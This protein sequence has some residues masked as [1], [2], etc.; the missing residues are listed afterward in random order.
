MPLGHLGHQ[1]DGP[2]IGRYR[3]FGQPLTVECHRQTIMGDRDTFFEGDRQLQ[4]G[5][6]LGEAAAAQQCQAE[7][8]VR[9]RVRRVEP[10]RLA[11]RGDRGRQFPRPKQTDPLPAKALRRRDLPPHRRRMPGIGGVSRVRTSRPD[12][13][14]RVAECFR[15]LAQFP[16]FAQWPKVQPSGPGAPRQADGCRRGVHHAAALLEVTPA[17][18]RAGITAARTGHADHASSDAVVKLTIRWSGAERPSRQRVARNSAA[19]S[20]SHF[21]RWVPLAVTA[22]RR[23]LAARSCRQS[24]Q[25]D[26]ARG[27]CT[28]ETKNMANPPGVRRGHALPG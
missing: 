17:A 19:P 7:R 22:A 8:A 14:H 21:R 1:L 27:P 16:R 2:A 4:D 11:Q 13:V 25:W 18:A 12:P 3:L 26:R 20:A 28:G 23:F 6:C 5:G 24:S 10:G 9:S 15:C